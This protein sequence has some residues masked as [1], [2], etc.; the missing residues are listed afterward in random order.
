MKWLILNAD[1]FIIGIQ[2]NPVQPPNSVALSSL[3]LGYPQRLSRYV[4]GNWILLEESEKREYMRAKIRVKVR[5]AFTN[6][7]TDIIM[8]ILRKLEDQDE[9]EI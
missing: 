3:P 8:A 9:G 4:N 1:G 6:A 2:T 7:Q 5:A